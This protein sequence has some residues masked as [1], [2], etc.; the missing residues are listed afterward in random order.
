MIR[1]YCYPTPNSAKIELFLGETWLLRRHSRN[2]SLIVWHGEPTELSP[3][4]ASEQRA[5]RGRDI[6]LTT[7]APDERLRTHS[8]GCWTSAERPGERRPSRRSSCSP[9]LGKSLLCPR[10][11]PGHWCCRFPFGVAGDHCTSDWTGAH[12]PCMVP[13]RCRSTAC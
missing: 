10:N 7:F 13:L 1:F 8:R 6:N 5:K 4:A 12:G 2:E 9:R 11:V 3:V